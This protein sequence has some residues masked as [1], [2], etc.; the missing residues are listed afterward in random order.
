MIEPGTY[1]HSKGRLYNVL[2]TARHSETKELLVIYE[3][4]ETGQVWARPE[5]MWSETVTWPDGIPRPRFV[6]EG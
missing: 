6:R 4:Q 2:M 3:A 1:R 5:S